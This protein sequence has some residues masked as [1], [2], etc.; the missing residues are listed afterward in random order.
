MLSGHVYSARCQC[1]GGFLGAG[2]DNAL[3]ERRSG[4]LSY[5]GEHFDG[6]RS[7]AGQRPQF[8]GHVYTATNDRNRMGKQIVLSFGVL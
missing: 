2:P 7:A 1:T 8:N 6:T 5:P 3:Q 4:Q